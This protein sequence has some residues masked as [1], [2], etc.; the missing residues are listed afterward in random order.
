MVLIYGFPMYQHVKSERTM[1]QFTKKYNIPIGQAFITDN[2][3]SINLNIYYYYY[4]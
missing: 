1:K 4:Y 3:L 2:P